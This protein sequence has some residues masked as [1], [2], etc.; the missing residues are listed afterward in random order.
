[1]LFPW[2]GRSGQ[3]RTLPCPRCLD[4]PSFK[5]YRSETGRWS[6]A[7]RAARGI[8]R[9][10]LGTRALLTPRLTRSGRSDA[11]HWLRSG[12]AKI[13]S[14][15]TNV[16]R[17]TTSCLARARSAAAAGVKAASSLG[18]SSVRLR[19]SEFDSIGREAAGGRSDSSQP[20]QRT[21]KAIPV[22][23][24]RDPRRRRR[25]GSRGP[26]PALCPAPRLAPTPRS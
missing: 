18:C 3:P 5:A 23:P 11:E 21:A 20:R 19:T 24:F 17:S 6:T 9:L 12:R 15:F 26:P 2:R 8:A 16:S 25:P 14:R 4:R 1:M 22:C 10:R 7:C 13:R